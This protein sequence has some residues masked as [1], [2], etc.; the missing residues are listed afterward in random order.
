MGI[1]KLALRIAAPVPKIDSFSRY[2]FV[3]PHP[4]D[5][6]I[7]AGA[8]VAALAAQGK[9]ICFLICTDGRYG[10]TNIP[11][12]Y[13]PE[14]L[15]SVRK[16]EAQRSASALGVRDVRFLEL[17]D[18]G[19]Y[20]QKELMRGIASVIYDFQP[21]IVFAPDPSPTSECHIDHLNVGKAVRSLAVNADNRGVMEEL[22]AGTA[23]V[24]AVA[25]YMTA[26][27]NTFL[28]TTGYLDKQLNAI[29]NNHLSQY[30]EG[31]PDRDSIRLYLKLRAVDF[32]MR[33]FHLNAEGFRVL[34]KTH[35]HCLP[36]AGR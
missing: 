23:P 33:S 15:I 5:I 35:M 30:P 9:E 11:G 28:K 24:R 12:K 7:G 8:S 6:E 18:G 19:F 14:E 26:K 2:L 36:E 20:K 13:S 34:G 25:F 16:K 21:D 3:G 27:P 17:S 22:G 29:F 1:T 10:D 32:G 31:C 4:D